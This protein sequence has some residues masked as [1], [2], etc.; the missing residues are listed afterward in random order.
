MKIS[1]Y[2]GL[3]IDGPL[4]GTYFTTPYKSFVAPYSHELANALT[5]SP[6]YPSDTI[7]KLTYQY[8]EFYAMGYKYGFWVS[9]DSSIEP[10][11]ELVHA[12]RDFFIQFSGLYKSKKIGWLN[13]S[14][15]P[16]WMTDDSSE[17]KAV[18]KSY[19]EI[20]GNIKPQ[21]ILTP[22][23]DSWKYH[24]WFNARHDRDQYDFFVVRYPA[25]LNSQ[26]Y[27]TYESEHYNLNKDG[28]WVK[29]HPATVMEPSFSINGMLVHVLGTAGAIRI[30][31]DSMADLLT[32]LVDH[33]VNNTV[34][35]LLNAVDKT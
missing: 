18:L 12:M 10:F 30:K 21:S 23:V 33:I 26:T 9:D 20:P 24:W 1:S 34:T 17:Y 29:C 2:S 25:E 28:Q 8:S 14:E 11:K 7:K 13:P 35:E 19:N 16:E 31:R 27:T 32:E 22:V 4:E 15:L 6:V 3:C 5:E